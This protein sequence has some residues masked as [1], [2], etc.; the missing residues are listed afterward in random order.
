MIGELFSFCRGPGTPL[1]AAHFMRRHQRWQTTFFCRREDGYG[2]RQEMGKVML[3]RYQELT[4][5]TNDEVFHV[6]LDG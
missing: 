3:S 1:G 4:V 6:C 2:L 5:R